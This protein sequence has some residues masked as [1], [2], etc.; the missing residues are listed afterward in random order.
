M[1]PG[2]W[3][4]NSFMSLESGLVRVRARVS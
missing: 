4:T 3:L 2:F 1:A